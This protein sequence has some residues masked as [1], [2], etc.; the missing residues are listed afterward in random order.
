LVNNLI[1][2]QL[3]HKQMKTTRTYSL[4]IIAAIA[5]IFTAC[6]KSGVN[7]TDANTNSTAS[8][9]II[10]VTTTTALAGSTSATTKDTVFLVN[11]FGPRDKKDSVA[12]SALPAAIGTYLTANYSGYTV[13]KS[14]QVTDAAKAVVNYIVVI[15]YNGSPVGLKFTPAGV[16]V[17]VL[18]QRTGDDIKG[19]R[20]FHPGGPF[21]NR[22]GQHP[23]TVALSAVP[24]VVSSFFS[25]SYPTDTLLHA[26]I[27]PD[28]T[29]ILISKNKTLFATAIT[30]APKLVKRIQIDAQP[31][32][33]TAVL[34]AALPAA[35]GTYLTATYPGY[36]FDKAFSANNKSGVLEYTVFITSNN[37]KFAL[38]FDAVG[39]FVKALPIR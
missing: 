11:C 30:T 21:G 39:V 1:I 12:F 24:T 14:I 16:F 13:A 10:A 27:A 8:T 2:N 34:Q 5:S 17:S 4:L 31:A 35:I 26:A 36:V 23:D 29:Y 28:G 32:K 15:N 7:P 38:R 18:E 19:G 20:G 25:T 37:T 6:Q 3:K 33:H 9:G 22:N